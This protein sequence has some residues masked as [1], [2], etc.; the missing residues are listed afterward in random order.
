MGGIIKGGHTVPT[1]DK[2]KQTTHNFRDGSIPGDTLKIVRENA[3]LLKDVIA[4]IA[5]I[6]TR[7]NNIENKIK[8][9]EKELSK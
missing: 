1:R 2:P 5:G 4:G 7:L 8:Q 3:E 6:K 9:L